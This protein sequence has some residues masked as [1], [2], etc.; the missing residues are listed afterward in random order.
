M[1]KHTGKLTKTVVEAWQPK[2]GDP[3]LWDGLLARFGVKANR[4]GS[5]SYIL[6]YHNK[7]GERR[8]YTIGKH[9]DALTTDAARKKASKLQSE[10]QLNGFDPLGAKRAQREALTVNDLLDEYVSSARFASNAESTQ[11]SDKSRIQRHIRPLLGKIKL[12]QLSPDMVRRMFA[13]IRDGKTAKIK[14]TKLRGKSIV[15]G[16]GGAARQSVRNLRAALNWAI[17]EGFLSSNPAEHVDIG[18]DG[19]R[20]VFIDTPEQYARLFATLDS[21]Q[22]SKEVS[23]NLADIIRVLALTGARLGEIQ[24]V[25]WEYLDLDKGFIRLPPK[26]HKAGHRSGKPKE[27]A[28]PDLAKA[29]FDKRHGEGVEG[30]V[31]RAS[32]GDGHVTMGS[33]LW[34]KICERG[35]L[36]KGLTSHG[37]R[38]SLGTYM[39]L[40]GAQEFELMA[41]LG[42]S[43]A[44]TTKRY[45]HYAKDARKALS[46]KYTAGIAAAVS[47]SPKADVVSIRGKRRQSD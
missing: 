28:L 11:V 43:Q 25:R 31:F 19:V 7:Y 8:R 32:S 21:L 14:K 36:P 10:I 42:H 30:Y 18:V 47:D 17:R 29:I 38:H 46:D 44:S 12:E 34:V 27:I 16:G 22:S 40:Q 37:L 41:A 9:G 15:R 2:A 3:V 1:A 24:A 26:A 13:Q 23:E 4:N 45:I 5:K 6:D 39:A 35:D 33:S 20:D